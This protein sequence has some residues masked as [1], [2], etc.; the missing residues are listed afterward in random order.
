AA[1]RRTPPARGRGWL[2]TVGPQRLAVSRTRLRSRGRLALKLTRFGGHRMVMPRWVADGSG[3]RPRVGEV[4]N[5]GMP[6][7]PVVVDLDEPEHRGARHTGNSDARDVSA[8]RRRR[9]WS[10]MRDDSRTTTPRP[11]SEVAGETYAAF[12]SQ[13]T[14]VRNPRG[15]PFPS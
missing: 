8:R 13:L 5:R 1:R 7:S 11:G 3:V 10:Q 6:A 9:R 15:S 2:G 12:D 14:P 4:V